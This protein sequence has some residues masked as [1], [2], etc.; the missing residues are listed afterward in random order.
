[1][2]D[3]VNAVSGKGDGKKIPG[4]EKPASVAG[5]TR[6]AWRVVKSA[7]SAVELA[8]SKLN[9]LRF[10]NVATDVMLAGMDKGSKADFVVVKGNGRTLLGR[11]TAE[12]QSL[13]HIGLSNS[14]GGGRLG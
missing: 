6:S 1:M 8:I 7:E 4:K 2:N 3:Q 9:V 10:I 12:V 13:L 5:K 11:K 14:V